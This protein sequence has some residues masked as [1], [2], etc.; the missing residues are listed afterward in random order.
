[1]HRPQRRR[2]RSREGE[3]RAH[4]A[5]PLTA[6][7][8]EVPGAAVILVSRAPDDADAVI[9]ARG[10]ILEDLHRAGD[11]DPGLYSPKIHI[12]KTQGFVRVAL[13]LAFWELLHAPDFESAL[14]DVVNR[15]GDADTNGAIAGALLGA[16]Y[17]E[18]GIPRRWR[19]AVESAEPERRLKAMARR[20][21]PGTMI[22]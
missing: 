15:G 14:V 6:A 12:I 5:R 20:C 21:H 11:A 19:K 17:G 3:D 4:H 18:D 1:V 7:R 2:R 22:G 13:R 16:R 10:D 9:S 8:A